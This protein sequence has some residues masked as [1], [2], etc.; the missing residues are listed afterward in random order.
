MVKLDLLFNIIKHIF[1]NISKYI[2]QIS[3]MNS[4]IENILPIINSNKPELCSGLLNDLLNEIYA[5]F[6][7][8]EVD[9]LSHSDEVFNILVIIN[10]GFEII[11]PNCINFL[12]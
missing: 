5:L 2:N 3:T 7:E 8:I 9:D 6:N 11:G 1:L 10:K 4:V 12:T